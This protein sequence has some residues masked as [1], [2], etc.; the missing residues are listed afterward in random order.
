VRGAALLILGL[1]LALMM[2]PARAQPQ[3]AESPPAKAPE[4]WAEIETVTVR[5]EPGPAVW[6]LTRGTSEVWILGTVGPLSREMDWNRATVADM[7]DGARAL[8]LSP[9]ADFNLVD[10]AWFLLRHGSELSLPRGQQLED[11]LPPD[12][13]LRFKA[14]IA[15]IG[16]DAEDYRTDIPI[17]AAVRLGQDFQKKADLGY[18]EPRATVESLASRKRISTAPV[19]RFEVMDAVRDL[20]KLTPDQQRACLSQA[21]EDVTW[22]R[23]HALRAARAWAVGDI[24]TVKDHYSESRLFGCVIAQ[25]ER[26]GDINARA[27]AETVAAIDAALN[28]PGKTVA[29]VAMG[30]LLRRDGVLARLKA[31]GVTIEAPVE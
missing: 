19:Y 30:P 13:A 1:A 16:A 31:R 21:V 27:T 10:I 8:L 4:E 17:R 11:G 18:R 7:L 3:A 2:L 24:R 25:V 28:Q 23:A 15:V 12:L 9:R 5:A 14:A 22:A 29:L 26:I 20:L 6:R